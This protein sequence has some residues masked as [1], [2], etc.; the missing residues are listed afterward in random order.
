MTTQRSLIPFVTGIPLSIIAI[1][2]LAS[3]WI[4]PNATQQDIMTGVTAP[5]TAGHLF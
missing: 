4:V 2:V 5:G 3:R 1:F